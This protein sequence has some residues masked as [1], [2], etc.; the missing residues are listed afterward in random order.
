MGAGL[1]MS[2]SYYADP[3]HTQFSCGEAFDANEL[4][5]IYARVFEYL[6]MAGVGISFGANVS[7]LE[8]WKGDAPLIL[9][10]PGAFS[11]T[12]VAT[13]QRLL[14]RGVHIAAFAGG[15]LNVAANLLKQP[16]IVL[17][18]GEAKDLT[19]SAATTLFPRIHAG[20]KL[21]IIFP[22][23]TTGYGFRMG[24]TNFI[25]VEDWLEE[26]RETTLRVRALGPAKTA[27]ACNVN[28]HVNVQVQR[29][30]EHWHLAITLRPGD[31]T[32]FA[33]EE[34]T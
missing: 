13:I 32:L 5:P 18:E 10:N 25:V 9:M 7:A 4:I 31:G 15:E 28:D 23:G 2:S 1:V 12:E 11:G 19:P 16:G 3:A 30:G 14:E 6:H 24:K 27:T 8:N 22:E 33:L 34:N 20:L 21:S 29:D 26:G 17:L